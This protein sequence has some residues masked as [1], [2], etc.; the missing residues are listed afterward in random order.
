MFVGPSLGEGSRARDAFAGLEEHERE[1][2]LVFL[3]TL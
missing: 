2:L 1:A 3:G